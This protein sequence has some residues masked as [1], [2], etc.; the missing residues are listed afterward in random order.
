MWLAVGEDVR[1]GQERPRLI[2]RLVATW[3]VGFGLAV[4]GIVGCGRG[5]GAMPAPTP[6]AA[7]VVPVFAQT[8]PVREPVPIDNQFVVRANRDVLVSG[9]VFDLDAGPVTVT[10][11]DPGMRFIVELAV[12]RNHYNPAVAYG[13]G[14]H[15][16]RKG[17]IGTRYVLVAIRILVD[18]TDPKDVQ[19]VHALQDA[20]Q[21]KQA[22]GPGR[23]E[24]PNWD[25]VSQKRVRDALLVLGGTL[26]D[27]KRT[28]GR[29]DQVDPVRHL[30][31]TAMGW[32]GNNEKDAMYLNVTPSQNDGETVYRHTVRD[33]PVEAFWS[34]SLYNADGYFVK[35]PFDAYNLN[36]VTAKKG[37][38]VAPAF[39]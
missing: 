15:T 8:V 18:P 1:Q 22:G 37:A 7:T 26:P 10:L 38:H 32:G 29:R 19:Q 36:S 9:A 4:T 33:V 6:P 39:S 3:L 24:A 16:F 17:K 20:I 14:T 5:P 11:P 31:G 25:P 34:I 35:N 27:L 2:P 30:I 13:A 21:V 12:D 23:Y 28:F